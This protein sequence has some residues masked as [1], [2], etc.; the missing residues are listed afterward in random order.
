M[1]FWEAFFSIENIIYPAIAAFI[2]GF[3]TIILASLI[4]I[5]IGEV[6]LIVI[7]S[8]GFISGNYVKANSLIEKEKIKT[9]KKKSSK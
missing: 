1:N 9:K 4:S 6:E 5:P 8:I 7:M 2:F 3:I